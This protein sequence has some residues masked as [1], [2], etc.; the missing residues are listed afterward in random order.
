MGSVLQ[1][2]AAAVE[3]ACYISSGGIGQKLLVI[4]PRYR[5]VPCQCVSV[6]PSASKQPCVLRRHAG[7]YVNRAT[8]ARIRPRWRPLTSIVTRPTVPAPASAKVGRCS[9]PWALITLKSKSARGNT[10]TVLYYCVAQDTDV[11]S[12]KSDKSGNVHNSCCCVEAR[13]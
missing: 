3:D 9:G 5:R 4:V 1:V 2:V 10:T 12:G 11:H 8:D 13:I 7:L 6:P